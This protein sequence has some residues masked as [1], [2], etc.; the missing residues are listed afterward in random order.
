MPRKRYELETTK[1]NEQLQETNAIYEG[2]LVWERSRGGCNKK[3]TISDRKG[4]RNIKYW[5]GN[6][7]QRH[8]LRNRGGGGSVNV[9]IISGRCQ[10]NRL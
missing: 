6:L 2:L 8:C 9:N 1:E 3:G 4:R 10:G 7:L 5:W